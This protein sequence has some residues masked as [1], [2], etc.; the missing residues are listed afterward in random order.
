MI[1]TLATSDGALRQLSISGDDQ[2]ILQSL[3]H[4]RHHLTLHLH[5]V[6][7]RLTIKADAEMLAQF[8]HEFVRISLWPTDNIVIQDAVAIQL[9]QHDRTTCDISLSTWSV[10]PLL[11]ILCEFVIH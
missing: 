11:Y 4:A 1:K 3:L 6:G 2:C 10:Q 8:I 9:Q 5:H 7:N